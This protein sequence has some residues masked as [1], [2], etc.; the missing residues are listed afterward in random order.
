MATELSGTWVSVFDVAL[1]SATIHF[2]CSSSSTNPSN[3]ANCAVPGGPVSGPVDSHCAGTPTVVVNP[4]V[5][6]VPMQM[7]MDAGADMPEFG[8]TMYNAE[9]DDD[10]C[11][12]H[13]QWASSTLCENANVTFQATLTSK[14]DGSAVAGATP[15][16]EVF[17]G[18]EARPAP[19]TNQTTSEPS[20]GHYT[21]GPIQ[22]DAAGQWT[23]RFHFFPNA[24][25]DP[26]SPHGHA[27]FY[28]SVP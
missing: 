1:I 9:G 17:L 13:V 11:K 3:A 19:L 27:A 26:A 18:T 23:T 8:D 2:G 15:W 22:F 12:Y 10:D 4:T 24:C 7:N 6:Q 25:D 16:A 21:I 20:A 5:C 28:V 14:I